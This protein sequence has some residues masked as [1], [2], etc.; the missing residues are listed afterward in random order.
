LQIL[1]AA[2]NP[3]APQLVPDFIRTYDVNFP[4]GFS[5]REQVQEYI[6]HPPNKP[7]YVPELMFID[8]H[9]VIRAQYSGADDF[10]KDQDKNIRALAETLLK[11][12]VT[13]KKAGH[14]A[15]KKPS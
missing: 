1:G 2:F 4:V 8:R 3:N 13:A 5:E 7:S 15:R 9:R 6:Q 12:P 14:G 11:E 10:F